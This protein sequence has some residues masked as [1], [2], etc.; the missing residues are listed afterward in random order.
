M[1]R[2]FCRA[3]TVADLCTYADFQ[4][5]NRLD[6][7]EICYLW[8]DFTVSS[9]PIP[10]AIDAVVFDAVTPEWKVFCIEKLGFSI[11]ADVSALVAS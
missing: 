3:Y 5:L 1:L 6:S 8:N 7:D 9:S 2:I 4:T 11:P 10:D